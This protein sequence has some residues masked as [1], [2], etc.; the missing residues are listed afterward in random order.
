MSNYHQV[1]VTQDASASAYQIMSYLLLNLE[2]GRRTNLLPSSD[3]KIQDVY[4]C[5]RDELN[6][7]LDTRLNNV[8]SSN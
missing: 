5:L 2:M 6:K 3:G 1:P 8:S 4:M 7:F